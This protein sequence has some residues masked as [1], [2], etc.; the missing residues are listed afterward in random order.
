LKLLLFVGI[1]GFIGAI[2]RF[3]LS[4]Y[5]QK[6]S[7]TNFPFGTLGV[8]II[9]SFLLGILFFIFTQISIPPNIKSLLTTGMM[10][11]FTTYSTFAF[12]TFL[13]IQGGS[14]ILA[15]L[16]ILLNVVLTIAFAAIGYKV[17]SFIT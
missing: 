15:T 16:N 6:L 17:L 5:F 13:L 10:G 4:G 11:A 14:Y 8:N 3:L 12:E 1:G 9:G 2:S 7:Q